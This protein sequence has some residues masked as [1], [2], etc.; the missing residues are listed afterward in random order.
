M[1]IDAY[2]IFEGPGAGAIAIEGETQD[3]EMA[4]KRP[5][6]SPL[7]AWVLKTLWTSVPCVAV[8]ALVA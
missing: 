4:K 8:L 6:R 5:S 2:V 7:S 3:D 1:S